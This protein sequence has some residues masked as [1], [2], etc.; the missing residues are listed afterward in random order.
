MG[1]RLPSGLS[2]RVRNKGPLLHHLKAPF[3]G[4]YLA[5]LPAYIIAAVL[6]SLTK[7]EGKENTGKAS[8]EQST[9]FLKISREKISTSLI[10]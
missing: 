7:K 10:L 2:E 5:E 4:A 9:L 3:T 1:A 6:W 8:K